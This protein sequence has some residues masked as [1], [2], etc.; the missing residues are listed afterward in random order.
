MRKSASKG[1]KVLASGC[2]DL[3]HA[4]H[5]AFLKEASAYG[6]LYV[7]VGSD[8][9][10]EHLKGKAPYFSQEERQYMVNAI[11]YVHQAFLSSGSGILD[12]KSDLIRLQ[13]EIFIEASRRTT[14]WY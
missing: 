14:L 11:R 3:M 13:P 9:N 12:F 8:R 10:I 5:I 4:G 1:K 7:A 2:F 6:E